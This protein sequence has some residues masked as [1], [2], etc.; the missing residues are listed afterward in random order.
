MSGVA[1]DPPSDSAGGWQ[2]GG[3]QAACDWPHQQGHDG[4][5][6]SLSL[7]E[8]SR[9]ARGTLQRRDMRLRWITHLSGINS[10]LTLTD[11]LY[12]SCVSLSLCLLQCQT[13][14][15]HRSRHVPG[16]GPEERFPRV[17]H[18]LPESGPHLSLLPEL[19]TSGGFGRGHTPV[20][21]VT[22]L[23]EHW[24]SLYHTEDWTFDFFFLFATANFICFNLPFK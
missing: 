22:V 6:R 24:C 10:Y 11:L 15:K 12:L 4:A 17:H 14:V 3:E 1:V 18:H 23:L 7:C 5:E 21:T 8:V 16:G 19:W 20:Q 13:E 9:Q 2:Q